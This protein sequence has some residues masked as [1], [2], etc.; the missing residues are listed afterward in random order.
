M[1]ILKAVSQQSRFNR[2]ASCS[3][4]IACSSEQ[5]RLPQQY[6]CFAEYFWGYFSFTLGRT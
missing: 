2:S 3:G 4:A 6:W 1:N 5:S